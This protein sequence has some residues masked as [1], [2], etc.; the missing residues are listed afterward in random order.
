MKSLFLVVISVCA[1]VLFVLNA[2]AQLRF[3]TLKQG[4]FTR[5]DSRWISAELIA[6]DSKTGEPIANAGL[7]HLQTYPES[8]KEQMAFPRL[9]RVSGKEPGHVKVLG[10]ACQTVKLAAHAPNYTDTEFEI[11]PGQVRTA[12]DPLIIKLEPK[13]TS[14]SIAITKIDAGRQ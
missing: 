11:V 13:Q 8:F 5:S 10:I 9:S 14:S 3:S 1:V 12:Q 2:Q 7:I 4:A 6:V